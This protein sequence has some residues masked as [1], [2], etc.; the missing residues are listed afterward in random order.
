MR[1]S[2]SE[3]KSAFISEAGGELANNDY[4]AFVELDNYACYVLASGITDFQTTEAA[5]LAVEHFI[6]SFEE[7][8][9]LSKSTLA[10]YAKE[11]NERLMNASST[12]ERMKA[13]IL[14]IVTD[15]E[16][17]RYVEAGNVR[18]RMYRQG[19]FFMNSS[20]TSL[21]KDLIDHGKSDTVLDRHAERHNLYAYLGK[22]ETFQPYVSEKLPLKDGDIISLYTSGIWEHVSEQ[23]IDGFF[24][25]ASN[26]PQETLDNL[27]EFMLSRQPANLGSYTIAAIF[28]NKSYR[29]PERE[30]KRRMYIR[31][32]IIVLVILLIV[33]I[34]AYIL[35]HR[36]QSKLEE[37]ARTEEEAV[38]YL[39]A[40]N[41]V[42]AQESCKSAME[43][44]KSLGKTEDEKRMRKYLLVVD[45]I[46]AGDE[47][48][49]SKDYSQAFDIFVTA[50]ENS[51][52]ADLIG[53]NYIE[54]RLNMTEEYL[55]VSDFLALGN[56]AMDDGD[57][58]KAE[59]IFYKAREKASIIHDSDGRTAAVNALENLYN[60]KAKKQQDADNKVKQDSAAAVTDAMKKGDDLLAKGDVA[61]AEKAYLEAR[62]IAN[63]SGDKNSRADAMKS[64]EQVHM[65]KAEKA[66][67]EEKLVKEKN[68]EYAIA[69]DAAS[70]G[71]AAFAKG[72]Y[73]S[74]TVYY[75]SAM[76]KFTVLKEDA[77]AESMKKKLD[78]TTQKQKESTRQEDDV[79]ATEAQA[80]AKYAAKDYAAAKQLALE[81]KRLYMAMGNQTKVEEMN[82]LITQIDLDVVIDENL[83]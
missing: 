17:F 4:F 20:D 67:K 6:L 37:L 44:A 42:R 59:S 49:K 13:S 56:K 79:K 51:Q 21:A 48:L 32:A 1:K 7:R 77:M 2:N 68:Q 45:S 47:A 65:A 74:A 38:E 26:E 82:N 66:E 39:S 46:L 73:I 3:F 71:D 5:K 72:D 25:E 34:I 43:Q 11:T 41:F 9:G 83:K 19:R 36:H 28:V 60:Q 63:A 31:I 8:P 12:R 75:Q 70:R 29:D 15:Y 55:Y 76:E 16:K 58:E 50:K 30:Q 64:L 81:A 33:G 62:S 27:E 18:M 52:E 10:Q 80:K 53:M 23:E 54:R 22:P 57:L 61:G 69:E 14:V 40:D 35:Y 78:L 24:R